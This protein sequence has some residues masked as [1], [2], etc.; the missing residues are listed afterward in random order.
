MKQYTVLSILALT[1]SLA[2]CGGGGGSTPGAVVQQPAQPA[3]TP[4]IQTPQPVSAASPF[5]G[6]WSGSFLAGDQQ[7]I[8]SVA[9]TTQGTVTG[10][11]NNITAHLRG[12]IQGT[13]TDDGTA[14]YQVVWENGTFGQVSGPVHLNGAPGSVQHLVGGCHQQMPN[15]TLIAV[16]FDL[17]RN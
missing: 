4:V 1:V 2:G 10:S 17:I 12:S 5:A 9:I 13:V 15:G 3:P 6:F 8:E 16:T 14:N 11:A 7:G